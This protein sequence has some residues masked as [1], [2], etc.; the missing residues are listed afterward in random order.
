MI[1]AN[2]LLW[3]SL[4]ANQPHAREQNSMSSDRIIGCIAIIAALAA[5]FGAFP[6]AA[7]TWPPSIIG[8][9]HMVANHTDVTVVISTR[10]TSGECDLIDGVMYDLG[11]PLK[12]IPRFD[13]LH[14]TYC[15]GSGEIIFRRTRAGSHTTY[16]VYT[17]N[18]S[19]YQPPFPVQWS[20]TFGEYVDLSN[21]GQYPFSATP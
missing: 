4:I 2:R 6:A 14:G 20:G 18:F 1:D 9:W 3:G 8:T 17:G 15:P 10:T 16:Q 13:G 19:Q 5:A 12:P 11:K 7:A 21:L